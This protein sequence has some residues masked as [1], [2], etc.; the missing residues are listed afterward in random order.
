MQTEVVVSILVALAVSGILPLIAGIMRAYPPP[1][2]VP[3]HYYGYRTPRSRSSPAM[4]NA[5]QDISGRWMWR[6]GWAQ[7]AVV[8]LMCPF[9]NGE[10]LV[11][12]AAGAMVAAVIAMMIITEVSLR[13]LKTQG[14]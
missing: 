13:R 10:W 5:A 9:V 3:H 1:R 7:F 2:D 14:R 12:L 8:L 4:W 11:M 6:L